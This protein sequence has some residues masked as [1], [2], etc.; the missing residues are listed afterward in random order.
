[1]AHRPVTVDLGDRG[2]GT[3]DGPVVEWADVA[4]QNGHLGEH[5]GA[6]P[7]FALGCAAGLW[8]TPRPRPAPGAAGRAGIRCPGGSWSTAHASPSRASAGH[9][10]G[11]GVCR[12]GSSG[13]AR[14]VSGFRFG[15]TRTVLVGKSSK[16]ALPASRK[17]L[18]TAS[19]LRGGWGGHRPSCWRGPEAR[20]RRRGGWAGPA[21][22]ASGT[23]LVLALPRPA[24][25]G[26]PQGQR[27]PDLGARPSVSGAPRFWGDTEPAPVCRA[28]TAAL[29]ESSSVLS[30]RS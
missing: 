20:P 17:Q 16:P 15:E 25:S 26:N 2:P 28:G 12:P 11:P 24:P 18:A 7:A 23:A 22:G 10:G 27:A 5:L 6:R 4:R 21:R 30:P 1:M 29:S 19:D 8:G 13:E 9:F 3:T 14:P